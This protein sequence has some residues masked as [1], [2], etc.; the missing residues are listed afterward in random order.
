MFWMLSVLKQKWN[1]LCIPCSKK[2]MWLTSLWCAKYR[3]QSSLCKSIAT[4]CR[5]MQSARRAVASKVGRVGMVSIISIVTLMLCIF[6]HN[7]HAVHDKHALHVDQLSLFS[8]V[9][10]HPHNLWQV[11]VMYIVYTCSNCACERCTCVDAQCWLSCPMDN[12]DIVHL[13]IS[14]WSP[15]IWMC[16]IYTCTMCNVHICTWMWTRG[17]DGD[18]PSLPSSSLLCY[19]PL[20][21]LLQLQ[22]W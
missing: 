17:K 2:N 6:I 16:F 11:P 19:P 20:L 5:L 3:Q 15:C 12:M 14:M 18:Y 9:Q 10:M 4:I 13:C 21:P 1:T 8:H 7:P 22:Y